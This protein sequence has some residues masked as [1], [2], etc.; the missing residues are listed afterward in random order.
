M[1]GARAI[2]YLQDGDRLSISADVIGDFD[3]LQ[4]LRRRRALITTA[5]KL[6]GAIDEM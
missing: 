2:P 5:N 1:T 4:D 6:M 3:T